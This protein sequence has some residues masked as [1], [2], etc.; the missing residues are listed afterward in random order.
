MSE[1]LESP[2]NFYLNCEQF[3]TSSSNVE[4][5]IKIE[6]RD[7]ILSRQDKWMLSVTRFQLDTQ[8]SLYYTTPDPTATMEMTLFSP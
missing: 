1:L 7:D 6:D 8:A 3:N 5:R 2:A 4:A